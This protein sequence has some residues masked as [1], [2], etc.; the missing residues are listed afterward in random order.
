MFQ[1]IISAFSF[2]TFPLIHPLRALRS[3]PCLRGT[4]AGAVKVLHFPFFVPIAPAV[5]TKS[6][7]DSVDSNCVYLIFDLY[8]I[9][10][11]VNSAGSFRFAK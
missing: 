10:F 1:F 8:S 7:T 3:S 5:V 11:S 6:A 2:L 9:T 4:V